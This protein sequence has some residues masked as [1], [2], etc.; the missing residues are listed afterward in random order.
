[1]VVVVAASFAMQ[2]HI[3]TS[4]IAV[5]MLGIAAAGLIAMIWSGSDRQRSVRTAMIAF[6]VLVVCWIP[7]LID[8]LRNS[9]G[10]LREIISFFLDN[11]EQPVGLAG[12][13][14]MMSQVLTLPTH[15]D[16]GLTMLPQHS[17][18]FPYVLVALVA[19]TWWAWRK[20]WRSPLALC[21][22]AWASIVVSI[23]GASRVA[24]LPFPYLFR[25]MWVA[26]G[27]AWAAVGLVGITELV[28]ESRWSGW[29][30]RWIGVVGRAAVGVVFIAA[31]VMGTN[32]TSL[33][34]WSDEVKAYEP[35]F[36]PA[37][38]ALRHAP[39]PTLLLVT[40]IT[41]DGSVANELLLRAGED[42]L[43]LKRPEKWSF[44]YGSGRVIAPSSAQSV[45]VIAVGAAGERVLAIPGYRLVTSYEPPK[46]SGYPDRITVLLRDDYSDQGTFN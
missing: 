39:K 8:Q 44:V 15:T 43:D 10:N 19:A 34:G 23:F 7:P 20:N 24:G 27:L 6:G 31:I 25:W 13:L 18:R 22:M 1:V 45:M 4:A 14:R 2:A 41:V 17:Y 29:W 46:D 3:G 21:A 42:G 32:M 28:E 16:V 37:L 40:D 35:V 12:G 26:G 9:P 36:A 38:D 33:N 30:Q 5:S 11:E